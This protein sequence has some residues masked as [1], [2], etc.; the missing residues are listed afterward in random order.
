MGGERGGDD[1]AV[2]RRQP[3]GRPQQF[4]PGAAEADR[5]GAE[6]L[7]ARLAPTVVETVILQ[8]DL[9]ATAAGEPASALRAELDLLADV[10]SSGQATVWRFSEP[11]LRRGF[12]AGR[13]A[14]DIHAF[15]AQRA[16]RDIPQA[17]SYLVDD[18]A[19]RY[20][21]ARSGRRP[22]T[23]AVRSRRCWRRC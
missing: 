13:N 16:A 22:A 20:G 3:W 18:M 1:R 21:R 17:L 10:E 8:A 7:L 19:R 6:K 11:S 4:R 2:R 9:T 14:G 15:L 5:G 23:C 12:D